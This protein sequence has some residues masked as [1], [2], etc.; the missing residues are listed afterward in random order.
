MYINGE[1]SCLRRGFLTLSS[2]PTPLENTSYI[3]YTLDIIIFFLSLVN[4]EEKDRIRCL[5]CF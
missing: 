3:R 1:G 4:E 2:L 5:S